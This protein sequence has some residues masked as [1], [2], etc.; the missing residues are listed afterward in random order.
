MLKKI[1][2]VIICPACLKGQLKI[3]PN[4]TTELFDPKDPD[5]DD[6][7]VEA[8]ILKCPKCWTKIDMPMKWAR[9][10]GII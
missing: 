5:N 7:M 9:K 2:V 6:T 8:I 3:D 1:P 4:V 10:R